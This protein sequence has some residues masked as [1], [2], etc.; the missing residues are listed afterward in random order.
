MGLYGPPRTKGCNFLSELRDRFRL[1]GSNWCVAGNFNITRFQGEKAPQGRA[2][3]LV[4]NFDDFI[5]GGVW[6][7]LPM[8]NGKFT[9]ANSRARSSIDSFSLLRMVRDVWGVLAN[10]GPESHF[11]SLA[12]N[13]SSGIQKMGPSPF[14]FE[15]LWLKHPSIKA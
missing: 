8:L 11:K 15:N 9:W 12:F 3:R 14:H 10:G 2:T 5:E 7:D 6:F 4:R 1:C 13:L